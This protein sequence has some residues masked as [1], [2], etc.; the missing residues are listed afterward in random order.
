MGHARKR[1]VFKV[2][3]VVPLLALVLAA[4]GTDT[5]EATPDTGTDPGTD[6]GTETEDPGTDTGTDPGTGDGEIT[7]VVIAV[8]GDITSTDCQLT[9]GLLD[10]WTLENYCESILQ[11][12]TN[13]AELVPHIVTD[14]EISDD[15][16]VWT[17]NLRDDV[18]FHNGDHFTA[19]DLKASVERITDPALESS[20]QNFWDFITEV[21]VLDDYS[22]EFH[23]DEPNPLMF[24]FAE[25]LPLFPKSVYDEIGATEYTG[26]EP[27]GLGAYKLVEWRRDDQ[28]VFEAFDDYFLGRPEIDRVIFRPIPDEA[29]RVAALRAGE[30]DII[31]PMSPHQVEQVENDPELVVYQPV[32]LERVR[33]TFDTRREPFTDPRV[34][35]AL[36]HAVDID[37]I[38][39]Q[40]LPGGVRIYGPLVPEEEGFNPNL[41]PYDY[42]PDRARELLAE[43]G[44]PDGFGPVEFSVSRGYANSEEIAQAMASQ[45]A[46]VGVQTEIRVYEGGDFNT[47]KREKFDNPESLGPMQFDG[48]AGGNTFHGYHHLMNVVGCDGSPVHSGYYCN[49]DVDNL[50][51]EAVEIWNSDN[52]QAIA[53]FHEAQEIIRDDAW[54]I[55][56]WQMPRLYGVNANL[57]WEPDASGQMKMRLASWN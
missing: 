29:A 53:N 34:R 13:T 44:Y 27:I 9:S 42:D 30:V 32:S 24:V 19:E 21:V 7:E 40:L 33:I 37:T 10:R 26:E 57:D 49:E 15:E 39:E 3:A 23:L 28:I 14:W 11:R 12:D 38:G 20:Q 50:I 52:D 43:A 35:Q 5:D 47:R 2:L 22:A 31:F 51:L 45:L 54:A 41:E 16:L 36:N 1:L 55:F 18:Y 4:C 8:D 48:H 6:T 25:R 46:E 17:L 56:L